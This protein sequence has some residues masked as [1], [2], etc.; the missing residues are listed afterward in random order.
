MSVPHFVSGSGILLF[1]WLVITFVREVP[2]RPYPNL[3]RGSVPVSARYHAP[4]VNDIAAA[5]PAPAQGIEVPRP[6]R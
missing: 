2:E 6:L 4:P 5:A 3:G 1:G